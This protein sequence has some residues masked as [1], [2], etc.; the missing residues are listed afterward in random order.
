[1]KFFQTAACIGALQQTKNPVL[2]D[3][4]FLLPV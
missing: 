4:I 3:G 2:A 1:M